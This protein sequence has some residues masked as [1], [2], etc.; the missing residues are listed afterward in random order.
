MNCSCLRDI[1]I[2]IFDILY[3]SHKLSITYYRML[4]YI[5]INHN[6]IGFVRHVLVGSN[7]GKKFILI[8]LQITLAEFIY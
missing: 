2:H 4:G 1:N 7:I 5:N 3:I 8:V 6:P